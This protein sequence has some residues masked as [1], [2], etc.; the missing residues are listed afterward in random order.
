MR[1]REPAP[2][3]AEGAVLLIGYGGSRAW[4]GARAPH[5]SGH[6]LPG[7]GGHQPARWRAAGA[8]RRS[9]VPYVVDAAVQ[10]MAGTRHL[11]LCAAEKPVTFFAYPGKPT[12]SIPEGAEVHVLAR[13]S[14][15]RST[16]WR[17]W[18]TR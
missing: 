3:L 6:R 15:T 14:R 12:T 10:A 7:D 8:A 9:C 1:P 17:G 16:R 5:R 13:R 18:P 4:P 2:R 11:I